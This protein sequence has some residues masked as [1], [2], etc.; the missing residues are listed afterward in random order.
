MKKI[1]NETLILS[2]KNI[3][4]AKIKKTKILKSLMFNKSDDIKKMDKTEIRIILKIGSL[5][6]PVFKILYN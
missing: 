5:K 6:P 4:I 2:I 3:E 1:L